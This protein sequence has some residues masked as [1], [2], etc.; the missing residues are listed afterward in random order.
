MQQAVVCEQCTRHVSWLR[1]AAYGAAYT[2]FASFTS[3]CWTVDHGCRVMS[4]NRVMTACS[5]GAVATEPHR[6]PGRLHGEYVWPHCRNDVDEGG[7]PWHHNVLG[8]SVSALEQPW[9][10]HSL[11]R[12]CLCILSPQASG[13]MRTTRACAVQAPDSVYTIP[14]PYSQ[15]RSC[16]RGEH[17]SLDSLAFVGLVRQKE[18][19]TWHLGI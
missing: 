5:G 1:R 16:G 17:D 9:C 18:D 7:D 6:L 19:K 13:E 12:G 2:A 10:V 11:H 4:D 15:T 14:P 3:A 8:G